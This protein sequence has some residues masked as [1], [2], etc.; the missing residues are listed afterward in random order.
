MDGQTLC[1]ALKGGQRVY[2]TMIISNSPVWPR[3]VRRLGLDFVFLD[4]EHIAIERTTL[5]WM[6]RTYAALDMA[7]IV[8]IPSPD[9]YA[10]AVALDDGA[11]GVIAPYVETAAQV[12]A[13]RGAV[14]LRPVKG[15]KLSAMLAGDPGAL[16]PELVE[17]L[18]RRNCGNALIAMIESRPALEALDEILAVPQLDGVIIGPTDLTHSLGIPGQFDHPVFDQAVRTI[19]RKARARNVGAGI[20]SIWSGELDRELSWLEEGANLVVHGVDIIAFYDSL[21]R[22][23]SAL[24]AALGE[25]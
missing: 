20:H 13:L 21:S 9:P 25:P 23:F 4:T 24:R 2:G 18:D 10:A 15:Q 19:I 8:R 7:P 11:S 17:H 3:Q 16:E 6:C 14:K 12:Q 5:S 22:D 1:A